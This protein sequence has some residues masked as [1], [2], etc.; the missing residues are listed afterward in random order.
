MEEA[1]CGRV[2]TWLQGSFPLYEGQ[3]IKGRPGVAVWAG[4]SVC[5]SLCSV[6]NGRLSPC[7]VHAG[8][9]VAPGWVCHQISGVRAA[10]GSG[11]GWHPPPSLRQQKGMPVKESSG[12]KA[13]TKEQARSA[14]L[15]GRAALRLGRSSAT[16][17]NSGPLAHPG[18]DGW[19]DG[20]KDG[21]RDAG[22]APRAPAGSAPP[23]A[24][25]GEP[26][27]GGRWPG[28]RV[29]GSGA[30]RFRLV[31]WLHSVA[32]LMCIQVE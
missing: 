13:Q 22:T 1:I 30:V 18:T 10:G 24:P 29:A 4:V 7:Q 19:T 11:K 28:G 27:D 21:R 17:A 15:T 26:R 32:L 16:R 5:L 9:E 6:F 2:K 8:R 25:R 23:A 14:E 20:W 31:A 3:A 12:R